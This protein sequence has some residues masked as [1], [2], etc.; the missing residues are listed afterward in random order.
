MLLTVGFVLI[1]ASAALAGGRLRSLAEVRFRGIPLLLAALGVQVVILYAFTSQPEWL[2]RSGHVLSYGLAGAFIW[3]NRSIPGLWLIGLGGTMNFAAIA[4]NGGVMPASPSALS[5]AGLP[6]T[7]DG[8]TNTAALA[9]ARLSFLGDIFAVPAGWPLS[10]VFSLGDICL[11]V[12]AAVAIHRIC[13]SRLVPSGGGQFVQ[14][15][16]HRSFMRLWASQAV[17]NLGDWVYALAV[18]TTL[19]QRAGGARALAVVLM[20]QVGPAAV[21]GALGG[22][23]IDRFSRKK[24]MIVSDVVRAAAVASLLLPGTVSAGHIYA[25]AALLGLFGALFQPSLQASLPN[26]VPSDRLVAANALVNATSNTAIT[27][28][29]ILGGLLVAGLGPAPAFS[30]NAASFGLSAAFLI[31]LRL[32]QDGPEGSAGGHGAARAGKRSAVHDLVEGGRYIARSPL[33]RGVMVVTGAVMLA[34][35]VRAPLEPMFVL[36]TLHGG[37]GALGAV[38][39]AWGLGMVLGSAASPALSHRWA[40]Q[41]LL[42]L[43]IGLVGVC[44]LIASQANAIAPVLALWVL[45]GTGNAVGTVA[46]ESLLQE[47]TPDAVRGRVVAA[48][49]AVLDGSFLVGALAAGW[50]GTSLGTRP[51]YALAGAAFLAAGLLSHLLLA[52]GVPLRAPGSEAGPAGARRQPP[53]EGPS[54]AAGATSE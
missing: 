20:M 21:A 35:A 2:P 11:V 10:N 31:G 42:G 51:G 29:P 7:S 23:L 22:P 18:G 27:I 15:T 43:S 28:G 12:G 30:L 41:H 48:S 17:S 9:G 36:D 4:A 14:L 45:S 24:L 19:A 3:A 25:V 44:G 8:F 26:V 39:G 33:V 40:R 52:R 53:R 1:L 38:G 6:A 13:G 47:R 32:P 54:V 46:Y 34:A 16:E 50:V 37:P 5:A 49:E